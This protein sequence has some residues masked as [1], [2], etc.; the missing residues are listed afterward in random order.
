MSTRIL[1]VESGSLFT[2]LLKQYE[3]TREWQIYSAYT[4]K[5]IRKC[6]GRALIDVILLNLI[7]LKR[8]GIVLLKKI[9]KSSVPVITIN[10]GNQLALSIEGM[11]LGAFDDFLM[12]LNLDALLEKIHEASKV[13]NKLNHRSPLI[14][15]LQN[16]LIAATFAEAGETEIAK[17]FLKDNNVT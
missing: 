16:T 8:Y 4:L 15:R 13:K 10:S 12:P 1:V 9:R 7:E 5:E 17:T 11:K 3:T 14:E 2:N 6:L